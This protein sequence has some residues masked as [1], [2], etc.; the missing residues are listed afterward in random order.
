MAVAR[1]GQRGHVRVGLLTAGVTA[2]LTALAALPAAAVGGVSGAASPGGTASP[3]GGAPGALSHFDLARSGGAPGAL[4][5]FDLARK[6]CVGTAAGRTSKVWY[7][8][9]NGVLSDVYEPTI[10]T[11]N[12]ETMQFVVTDGSTFTDLQ[13]RDATYTVGADATGMACTVTSTARN[14]RWRLM[15]TYLTDP[16][17]D[18]VL[19]S[20][21]LVGLTV[22]T[23]GLHL[24]VRLDP[25]VGGNGGGGTGQGQNA[26]ADSATV[27]AG[28]GALVA[29]DTTT[30]TAATNR[31]YGVPTYLAL[32]ADRRF[33]SATNGYV[34]SASDG[35]T[36]LDAAHRLTMAAGNAP[37]GNVVGTAELD[38]RGGGGAA[39]LALGFGR[40]QAQAVGTAGSSLGR[41][42]TAT[43]RA[44]QHGWA[45]YDA[46]LRRPPTSI[47]GLSSARVRRLAQAYYLSVNV[48]KASEDK[49]FP[50]AVVAGLGS[51]WGQAVSAG[52][53]QDGKAPYFGSYREV[54]S[55]DLYEAFTALLTAGDTATA[56]ASTR[57][58]LEHQQ[59]PDGRLPRNSLLNGRPAPDTGGDQLD[60]TS[61]PILMAL[62]SGL[63]G[64]AGLYRDHLRP[65]ADFVVAH[66][67][68]FGS[69][70]W[71]EQGGYSP[72]TIAAEIAGLVAAG[73]IAAQQHDPDRSKLYLAT[74]DHFQRSIKGWTVTTTGPYATGR[75]FLRLSKTGNPNAA[76]SYDLGNGALSADQRSVVDAGF[77]ELTRLGEL[78]ANDADVLASLAVVDAT[79]SRTTPSGTG[80]YRYG[81]STPG[82]E[83]GYGDCHVPDPTSCQPEGKP[84]PGGSGDDANK[85]SGHLWPVLSG[86]RAEQELQTGHPAPA[87]SLL[88]AMDRYSSGVGLV[89]EQDWE[90]APVPASPFG[91]DPST[92]SIGFQTGRPAGSAAPLTWAQAQEARLVLS[93]GAG[94]PVEQPAQVRARY[95]DAVPPARAPLTVSA[96]SSGATVTTA[97]TAVTGTTAPGARVVVAATNTDTGAATSVA[98]L[99]AGSDGTFS[100]TV[101]TGFGT[102]VLTITATTTAGATAYDQRIVS[103][104]QITGTPVLDVTDP[105]GD[106]SGP[107]TFQYPTAADFHPGA[108]DLTRFQVFNVGS[109]VLLRTQ[110]RNLSPTFGNSLGAQLLTVFAHEPG[111]AATSTAP[112]AASR[113]YSVASQDAWTR[114]VQVAGFQR[115]RVYDASGAEVGQASAQA[116]PTTG[117]ITIV[118]PK[119]L[120][121]G[122]PSAGWTFTVVLHG[123]DG[124]GQDGA[125]TFTDTA[126][127]YTFGRCPAGATAGVCSVPLGQLPKAM[128]VLTPAGVNQAVELDP[129]RGPVVLRGVPVP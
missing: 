38:L 92:A 87:A 43:L 26:G 110:L 75:Y 22:K 91:T 129:S 60:E 103:S 80:F 55:R 59:L 16:A 124:Y 77:T 31:D 84:W 111:A 46:S 28:S 13:T 34:G 74:A 30:A 114:A 100:V 49:T 12:V 99:T 6:D 93:L 7:T 62:Q 37:Q 83:D 78:P 113:G 101:P 112:L 53:A 90:D 54:F 115:T 9:A 79:L 106:D 33:T 2:A 76:I 41:S 67:P 5:H 120:L 116:S 107:G 94:H 119:A 15:T 86:E 63:G 108:F 70:R 45:G 123:Q 29:S 71:E 4:S 42:A 122:T 64:D 51:P 52:A 32:R 50:G 68:S 73:R 39:T 125:R 96:P 69:E 81:T 118:I 19:V 61:Y 1:R 88:D 97:T 57:F 44:Y 40:T 72:S 14:G 89:P 105:S 95:V 109:S 20:T 23:Q 10:D 47:A 82:T 21:R 85:G 25:S 128:D 104:D 3:S 48:V 121:G 18:T 66:G 58:L 35:L 127:A 8:V 17:R 27:D 11:T 102:S 65:A 126:G 36:Q 117:Y 24:Y 98:A 56:Q